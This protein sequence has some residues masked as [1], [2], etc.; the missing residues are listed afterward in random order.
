MKFF[1]KIVWF[2]PVISK[3]LLKF[4]F[5]KTGIICLYSAFFLTLH[6][7]AQNNQLVNYATSDGLPDAEI[8]DIAQ[9]N[10]QK[11]TTILAEAETNK[12]KIEATQNL[13]KARARV[14]AATVINN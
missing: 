13:R 11:A 7:S 10:L 4:R 6:L 12:Q 5:I 2:F 3:F 8:I 14:Q 1:N 9:D